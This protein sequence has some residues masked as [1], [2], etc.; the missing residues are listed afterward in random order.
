MENEE[1]TLV[2][3]VDISDDEE[4][5]Y[6]REEVNDYQFCKYCGEKMDKGLNFCPYCG[7]PVNETVYSYQRKR[8]MK[9]KTVA[10]LLCLFM[11]TAG[12]HKFYEGKIGMGFLY[13]FTG[14][15]LGIGWIIDLVKLIDKPNPYYV[16]D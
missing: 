14:G 4:Y 2:E 12:A 5:V 7:K 9:D 15:L 16:E 13:M 3:M 8:K 1:K 11:G 6:H 10:L